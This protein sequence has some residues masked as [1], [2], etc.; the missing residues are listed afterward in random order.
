MAGSTLKATAA[1][2]LAGGPGGFMAQ[3]A[4]TRSILADANYEDLAKQ[5]DPLDPLGLAVSTLIPL[6]FAAYGARANLRAMRKAQ[7]DATP[8]P[9]A[10]PAPAP[11]RTQDDI[12][13]AMAHNLTLR[14]DVHEAAGKAPEVMQELMQAAEPVLASTRAAELGLV[15]ERVT[16]EDAAPMAP[17]TRPAVQNDMTAQPEAMVAQSQPNPEIQPKP[18]IDAAQALI[19]ETDAAAPATPKASTDPMFAS[20]S[21]RIAEIENSAAPIV[22]RTTEDGRPVTVAD[23]LAAVRR[24]AAEGTDAELGALDADLVRVAAECALS[25]GST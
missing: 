7:P 14:A 8:A 24:E 23:E 12:D 2:Y 10:E 18:S 4:A 21:A 16:P 17:A 6:P 9:A 25:M 11:A 19:A 5:Y 1:L 3:Q 22:V 20:I 13:A 15:P